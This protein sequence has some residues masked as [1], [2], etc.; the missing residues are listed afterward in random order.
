M[1]TTLHTAPSTF[2]FFFSFLF[3]IFL[4]QLY[5]TI[6]PIG[7]FADDILLLLGVRTY[8]VCRNLRLF[9]FCTLIIHVLG[10]CFF[11]FSCPNP[12]AYHSCLISLCSREDECLLV[13]HTS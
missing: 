6:D 13:C 3:R 8:V 12:T 9:P 10:K 2:P 7:Y 4:A 11:Y 1:I 5:S